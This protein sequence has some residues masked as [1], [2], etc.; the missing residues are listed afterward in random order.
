MYDSTAKYLALALDNAE[1]KHELARW[2]YLVAQ[3]YEKT[4]QPNNA[5]EY[6]ARAIKHTYDPVLEVFAR[7]NSLRD[8]KDGKEATIQKNIDELVK[9]ARRDKY[10]NYR[11]LIYYTAAQMELE[12]KNEAGASLFLLKSTRYSVTILIKE[13]FLSSN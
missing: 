10:F 11:G 4:G 1:T 2:E 5:Q 13:T 8:N 3:L 6:F 9:M 12:R 7:L